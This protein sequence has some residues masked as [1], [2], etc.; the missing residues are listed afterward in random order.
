MA[1]CRRKRSFKD[2]LTEQM[3]SFDE[4]RLSPR[5]CRSD[6]RV[7]T[8]RK[9]P[10]GDAR[11]EQRLLARRGVRHLP[12]FSLVCLRPDRPSSS[13]QLCRFSSPPRFPQHQG[14]VL[15]ARGDVWM[16]GP[17]RL[18]PDRQRPLVKRLG[19]GVAGFVSLPIQCNDSAKSAAPREDRVLLGAVELEQL[20]GTCESAAQCDRH[21]GVTLAVTGVYIST[22]VHQDLGEI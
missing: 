17:E 18:L 10:K 6:N 16:I 5:S 2:G 15:Q 19:L 9:R 22:A 11:D 3:N 4:C 8:G 14:V 20:G 1:A 13:L 21:G 7:A 12:G